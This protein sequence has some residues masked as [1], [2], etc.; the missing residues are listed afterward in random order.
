MDFNMNDVQKKATLVGIQ[1]GLETE[2]YSLLTKIGINPETFDENA[3]FP[4]I[5]GS[6]F[7]E[8]TRVEQLIAALK[9]VK[10]KIAELP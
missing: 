10:D 8:K 3:A 2:V 4:E 7:G 9:R 6:F 5:D 1:D